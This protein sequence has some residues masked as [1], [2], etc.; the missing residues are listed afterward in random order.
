MMQDLVDLLDL[1]DQQGLVL[2]PD[3]VHHWVDMK[4]EEEIQET[5][6]LMIREMKPN[7]NPPIRMK[8]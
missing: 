8:K 1:V 5:L 3:M 6:K 2:I 4:E 7:R